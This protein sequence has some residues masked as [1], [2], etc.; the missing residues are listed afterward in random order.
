MRYVLTGTP[1]SGK[2]S[3]LRYLEDQGYPVVEEAA[4]AVIALRH[5]LG[6]T[7][8]HLHPSFVESILALQ[9]QRQRRPATATGVE[10]YDR[11]PICT[12]ALAV[13]LG[14]PVPASLSNE[15]DRLA[16]ERVYAREVFFVRN[17]GH[18]EPTAARRISF[19]D[20]LKFERVHEDVYRSFGYELVDVP[21]ASLPD[22][23]AMIL[24]RISPRTAR[25]P[26]GIR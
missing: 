2:T 22:R 8:P 3:I 11:S 24:E 6:E 13:W 4:T 10:F 26:T 17:L 16:K 20:A 5:A 19:E 1:G 21:P 7:E 15:V 9:Q 14:V 25:R 12:Y 18:V 23:T